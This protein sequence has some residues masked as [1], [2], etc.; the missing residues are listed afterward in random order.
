MSKVKK[1]TGSCLCGGVHYQIGGELKNLSHCHCSMCQ[2]THGAAFGTYGTVYWE[3]FEILRGKELIQTYRSSESIVRTF[4]KKCGST[5]QYI[6]DDQPG[7]GITAG[8]LDGDPKC[9][10]AEHLFLEN[11]APWWK[12]E[13]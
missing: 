8:T 9:G 1:L 10:S 11:Q 7:F 5:L 6:P 4:C 13:I 3:D 12:G 2:K